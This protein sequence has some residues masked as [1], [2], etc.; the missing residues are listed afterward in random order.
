MRQRKKFLA[1]EAV[2]LMVSILVLTGCGKA[3]EDI[4]YTETAE[5]GYGIP[6][7]QAVADDGGGQDEAREGD[8]GEEQG[9]EINVIEI[10]Q[11]SDDEKERMDELQA[12]Y[13]NETEKPEQE[14]LEVDSA[15]DVTEGTLCYIVSTGQFYLP[16]R[17]LTDEELLEII[18]C[19]FRIALNTNH[20]TQEE[21]DAEDRAERAELEAK[22]KAAGG[23]SE[24]EAIEIARKAMEEDIGE[25]AKGMQ[26]RPWQE[27]LGWKTDLCIADWSEI[28]EEDRGALGYYM[29]FDDYDDNDHAEDGADYHCTVNA[30]DGSILE[31]YQIEVSPDGDGGYSFDSIYYEH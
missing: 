10:R 8:A 29:Q 24:E 30:V 1:A 22:V 19:N 20:K 5:A 4:P 11:Y 7:V 15:D 27:R 6:E 28:K 23:I 14:I 31:A 12:S 21:W 18:D 2:L 26:L 25:K 9:A 16:D 17:E 3:G 13:Q